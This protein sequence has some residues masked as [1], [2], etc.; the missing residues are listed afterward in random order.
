MMKAQSS[1]IDAFVIKK[2][3]D[4]NKET[5]SEM[6]AQGDCFDVLLKVLHE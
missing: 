3:S 4:T 1:T 2:D 5:K 6:F